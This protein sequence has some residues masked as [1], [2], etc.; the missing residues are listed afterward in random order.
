[1]KTDAPPVQPKRKG[2]K[3]TPKNY[4]QIRSESGKENRDSMI[5]YFEKRWVALVKWQA[6][7]SMIYVNR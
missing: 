3:I 7:R 1:M 2:K 4:A 6:I 5:K